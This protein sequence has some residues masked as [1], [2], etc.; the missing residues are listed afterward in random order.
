MIR[1]EFLGRSDIQGFVEW[2]S[3]NLP[4]H[5]IQL[6]FRKSPNFVPEGLH[7]QVFGIEEAQRAYQWR[8]NWKSVSETLQLLRQALQ[9]AISNNDQATT[10]TSCA[11]ILD[12]GNVPRSK[13][14]LKG[15]AQD[16]KLIAYLVDK[17]PLFSLTGTQRLADLTKT[18]IPKFNSGMTKVHALLD[19]SGSPIYDGRVGAAIALLYHLYRESPL[20]RDEVDHSMF[21]WAPGKEAPNATHIRQIRNPKL[22]GKGYDGTPQLGAQSPHLWARRQL[23]LGWIIHQVLEKTNLFDGKTIDLSLRS[24]AFEAGLFMMGYDLRALI[25]NGWTIADPKKPTFQIRKSRQVLAI[26]SEV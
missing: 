7:V 11:A 18:S 21:G 3:L 22:L 1:D 19:S 13:E 10:Y 17:Q 20:A 12:W 8:G 25:P 9:D 24:H 4:T 5:P 2:L 6:H 16:G 23:I 14:F 26:H 15:L